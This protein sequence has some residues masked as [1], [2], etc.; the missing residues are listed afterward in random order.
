MEMEQLFKELGLEGGVRKLTVEEK[1][2]PSDWTKI[3]NC[4]NIKVRENEA[5]L[6]Q[7][8]LNAARSA[9]S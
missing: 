5:M 2:K 3:E 9:L 8:E 7:S 4:I 6:A 1:A